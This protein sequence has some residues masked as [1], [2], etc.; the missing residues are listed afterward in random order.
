M[1][2]D[3]RLYDK[4]DKIEERLTS[5]DGTLIR[6]EASLREHMR[7]TDLLEVHNNKQD[8][9]MVPLTAHLNMVYSVAK[10][11]AGLAI[12][13]GLAVSILK[14]IYPIWC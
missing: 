10:L 6:Q 7:R 9:A 12:L 5:I 11:V 4:L 2:I 13:A 3:S 8:L 14:I 1:E